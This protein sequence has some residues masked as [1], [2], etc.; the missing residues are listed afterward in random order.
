MKRILIL[1]VDYGY[2]HRITANAI[3]EALHETYGPEC[4]VDIVNPL[5]DPRAPAFLR[6]N[7]ESYDRVVREAPDLYRLGFQ[8]SESRVAGTL[9]NSSWTLMLFNVLRKILR[10]KQPDV[11]VSTYPLFQGILDAV[12]SVGKKSIPLLT[13]VTDLAR[14]NSAWFHPA[15]DLCLVPTAAVYNMALDAGLPPE[16]VKITGIPVRIDLANENRDPA[17]IRQSLGWRA[18][19]FTVLAAGS[20]RVEHMYDTLRVLNHSGMQLQLVV[21]TGGDEDLYQRFK[22]MEWHT[23][24]HIYNYVAEMGAF[25]KAA[26]CVLSKAGGLI[27]SETLASG[28]PLILIDVIQGQET[29]NAEYLIA[30]DAGVLTRDPIEVLEAMCHWL[31]NDRRLYDRMAT[32]ARRLGHPRS[33]FDVA[34]L[35]WEANP[36]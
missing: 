33:A 15:A 14:V 36:I 3:A 13:T 28:L 22:Q 5:N 6:K 17:V 27:I 32:N 9:L 31:E 18:D 16:K 12:F 24:A 34:R 23:E 4:S 11:I 1:T 19:L 25:L 30:E 7:Q 26:D 10:Q 21:A 20:K 35:V 8:V 29:G 2:G